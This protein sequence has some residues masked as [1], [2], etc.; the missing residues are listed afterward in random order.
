LKAMAEYANE[1]YR[2]QAKAEI[3]PDSL[4]DLKILDI[5]NKEPWTSARSV[6]EMKNGT[7]GA[8]YGYVTDRLAVAFELFPKDSPEHAKYKSAYEDAS[9]LYA[10]QIR[11]MARAATK[12][13]LPDENSY[14]LRVMLQ[15]MA[16]LYEGEQTTRSARLLD[17]AILIDKFNRGYE[18]EPD[19]RQEERRSRLRLRS[20]R[21]DLDVTEEFK[22]NGGRPSPNLG[23]QPKPI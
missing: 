16:R 1:I 13:R 23:N 21:F 4:T 6:W 14:D 12:T 9:G 11:N 8:V 10:D 15:S 7:G 5:C 3:D 17:L 20:V 18:E 2:A 19:E 22:R